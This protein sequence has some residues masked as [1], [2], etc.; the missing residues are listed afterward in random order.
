MYRYGRRFIPLICI[1]TCILAYSALDV[2]TGE[3]VAVKRI[4]IEDENLDQEIMVSCESYDILTCAQFSDHFGYVVLQQEVE[5]LKTMD[6]PNI[7]R[8]LGSVR[9]EEYLNIVL[10]YVSFFFLLEIGGS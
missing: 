10:E 2:Q 6:D 5:L 7:V 8:Y 9:D 3:I 1:L 4:K